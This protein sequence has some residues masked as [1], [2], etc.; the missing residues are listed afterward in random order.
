MQGDGASLRPQ[1][2]LKAMLRLARPGTESTASPM[3]MPGLEGKR[4]SPF[5]PVALAQRCR[6]FQRLAAEVAVQL[7]AVLHH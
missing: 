6:L 7:D 4:W 2:S 5:M 3:S 1:S